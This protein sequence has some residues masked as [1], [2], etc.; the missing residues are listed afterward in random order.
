MPASPLTLAVIRGIDRF[1]EF[2]TVWLLVLLVVP[3]ILANVAEVVLRYAFR[4]PTIW[5]LDVTTQSFGALFML[6]SA[7]AL[8]KG[9]HI[10][11]DMFW[12]KFRPRTKGAIDATA[13]VLLFLPAM[14]VLLYV[15]GKA[16][17]YSFEIGERSSSG[18]WRV[19][20]WPFRFVVPL[21]T[22]LLLIQ[23]LSELLKA[24]HAWRTDTLL[25]EHEKMEV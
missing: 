1:T 6:G 19:T 10:R 23:G 25:V 20:L 11:T 17:I 24:L 18:I 5:A 22:L 8:L 16:A 12:D 14:L 7:Y 13:Y 2:V 3:L 15:S 9:A 21:A 4:S